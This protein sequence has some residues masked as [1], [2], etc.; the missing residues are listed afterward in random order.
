MTLPPINPTSW[1]PDPVKRQIAD[2][3]FEFLRKLAEKVLNDEAAAKV[4]RLK[5]DG[6][7]QQALDQGLSRATTRFVDE[8]AEQDEDLVEA[9]AN[10][11]KFWQAKSVRQAVLTL[12]QH[13]G[14]YED[15][16]WDVVAE[17]FDDVLPGRRNRERVDRAVQFYLRCVVEEVW[18]LPPLKPI[19]ELQLQRISIDKAEAMLHEVQGMRSDLQQTM[20]ALARGLDEQRQ[21]TGGS[22]A[23][24]PAPPQVMQNLPQPDYVRFVGRETELAQVHTLLSPDNRT[25]VIVIDGIGGIGKSSLALEVTHDYFNRFNELPEQ[26]RFKAIIWTSAKALTLTADGPA[27]RQQITRTL[28]D[29]YTAIAAAL[30]REDITRTRPEEQ[31]ALV[32]QALTQQRTLLIIDN[33]ETIDDERVNAFLRELPAPTK[34]LV[35]TRHRIDVAYP[36]RLQ[37]LPRKDALNLIVQE[38]EKKG[39]IFKADEADRLYRHTGGVP[40]ALV[41]SIAQMGFGTSIETVL[42][43]IGDAEGDIARYCFQGALELIRGKPAHTLLMALAI[44]TRDASRVML[45]CIADVS[46]ADRDEGLGQ[47]ERLSL[48]NKHADRFSFLPLTRTFAFSELIRDPAVEIQL[49]QRWI[50]YLKD[51]TRITDSEYYWQY[52]SYAFRDEGE[53]ILDAV[54]WSFVHGSADDV[55]A[56]MTAAYEYLE[57]AGRLNDS[58]D[59][60]QRAL[61][62]ASSVHNLAAKA[63][64]ANIISWMLNEIG[65]Y[66]QAEKMCQ[67]ALAAYRSVS[68]REGES[69]AL[70]HL[71]IV[72]RKRGDFATAQIWID[73]AK[74][75]ATELG[76][77]DLRAWI[78]IEYGK[79]ARDQHDWQAAW[80]YFASVRD[81]FEQRVEQSAR[82]EPLARSTWGHMAIIAY[83]LGRPQEAKDL[84]LKSLEFFEHYGTKGYMA[85]LKYRLALAEE[86]LGEDDAAR[87]HAKEALEW[88]ERL[89]M[90]P[91]YAEALKLFERLTTAA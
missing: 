62:L 53:N 40:L 41:W 18:H 66:D 9:L 49:R 35:T 74:R 90:K 79:L 11:S 83:H 57:V 30:Q 2:S 6:D 38:C 60:C 37:A 25:W 63:R 27:P 86:A 23:A 70:H 21:L 34:C 72:Y 29:I 1:I 19:Y 69:V 55:F 33:M 64:L 77:G 76:D 52:G 88:F 82:D 17:N 58:L 51:I 73:S 5:S 61:G 4:A 7:F 81:W 44:F 3:L 89:G 59:L 39:V 31:D 13:P 26:Q 67:D 85:T 50:G 15:E 22:L 78:T 14:H 32:R 24:L 54:E 46:N 56:L 68:S 48:I 80:D 45:G 87:R 91:D 20:L 43:R 42:H 10:D 75:L 47:L 12:L 84:C 71:S 65:Q 36:V 28:S 16:A 8:Y